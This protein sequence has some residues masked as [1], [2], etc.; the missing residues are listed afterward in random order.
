MLA[1]F[2]IIAKEAML[3][4]L[5]EILMIQFVFSILESINGM[6]ILPFNQLGILLHHLLLVRPP[7]K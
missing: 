1:L 3:Q 5:L 4:L 6:I 2:V 7:L